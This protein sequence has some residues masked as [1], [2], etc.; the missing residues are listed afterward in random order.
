MTISPSREISKK[1]NNFTK[2]SSAIP[3]PHAKK[4]LERWKNSS[5]KGTS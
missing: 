5:K 1:K 4:N 2:L 3:K